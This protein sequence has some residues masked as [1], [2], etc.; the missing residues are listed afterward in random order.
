MK[1][2]QRNFLLRTVEDQRLEDIKRKAEKIDEELE[3]SDK[4][5]QNH[6]KKKFYWNNDML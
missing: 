4:R 6:K 2:I 5:K 1:K 3:V